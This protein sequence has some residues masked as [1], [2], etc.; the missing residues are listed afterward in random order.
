MGF[1]LRQDL[2]HA[3]DVGLAAD[4][5]GMGKGAR[6]RDQMLAAAEADFEPDFVGT[7]IEQLGK[8]GRTGPADVERKA[9]QQVFDQLSLVD[10]QLVTLAPSEERAVRASGVA[11][12][13]RRVAILG[14]AA[15]DAH[16]SV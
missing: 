1:D 11:V 15:P 14:I 7:R 8:I 4:E 13:G 3:V 5:A 10:A 9:R 12:V 6:F 16:R 2:R